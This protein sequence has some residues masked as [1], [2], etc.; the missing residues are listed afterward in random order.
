MHLLIKL[1]PVCRWIGCVRKYGG[2][3]TTKIS[4][5]SNIT[6]IGVVSL[7][8]GMD[9][10][11]NLSA[12]FTRSSVTFKV[13]AT[14]A[15]DI[16]APSVYA[17]RFISSS[18]SFAW[19]CA[20][21][22]IKSI[23]SVIQVSFPT[24]LSI[25]G[26]HFC[27]WRRNTEAL[28]WALHAGQKYDGCVRLF[29]F[30][31]ARRD[32]RNV[33]LLFGSSFVVVLSPSA[34]SSPPSFPEERARFRNPPSEEDIIIF[35]TFFDNDDEDDAQVDEREE[36]SRGS[37]RAMSEYDGR[38]FWHIKG[39]KSYK[40]VK[41]QRFPRRQHFAKNEENTPRSIFKWVVC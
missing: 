27:V 25:S 11:C 19:F 3:L 16:R 40:K 22:I 29:F 12:F 14:S 4:S 30:W 6:S 8:R 31:E 26:Q 36:I 24:A 5:F 34:S 13:C 23:S 35:V 37:M 28:H 41:E 2:L 15:C 38:I 10:E 39:E 21:A 32:G 9:F 33:T 7:L 1:V 20:F 17:K 18:I